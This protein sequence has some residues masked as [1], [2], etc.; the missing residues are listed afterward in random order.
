[1]DVAVEQLQCLLK[2]QV[3]ASVLVDHLPRIFVGELPLGGRPT[4]EPSVALGELVWRGPA[5]P[6][7]DAEAGLAPERHHAELQRRLEADHG[8]VLRLPYEAWLQGPERRAL[9]RAGLLVHVLRDVRLDVVN[10]RLNLL[11]LGLREHDDTRGVAHVR[12]LHDDISGVWPSEVLVDKLRNLLPL[13][14]PFHHEQRG[15]LRNTEILQQ[16]VEHKLV[17]QGLDGALACALLLHHR[18]QAPEVQAA[19]TH[20]VRP[21]K[22]GAHLEVLCRLDPWVDVHDGGR[23]NGLRGAWHLRRPQRQCQRRR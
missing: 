23:L 9:V 13:Y 10:G 19:R 20:G 18:L 2:P 4:H 15:H 11:R 7:P 5:A 3:L 16:P 6:P 8:L 1:M 14:N 22:V 21:V 17:A 12:R